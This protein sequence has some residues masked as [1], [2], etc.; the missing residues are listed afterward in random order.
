MI[1]QKKNIS[2]PSMKMNK[3]KKKKKQRKRGGEKKKTT[4]VSFGALDSEMYF[5]SSPIIL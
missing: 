5:K 1:E 3:G 4:R 2:I